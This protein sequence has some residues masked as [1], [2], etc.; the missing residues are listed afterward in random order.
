MIYRFYVLT[1]FTCL[2]YSVKAQITASTDFRARMSVMDISIPPYYQYYLDYAMTSVDR[3][4]PE[5]EYTYQF[6]L[7]H[8]NLPLEVRYNLNPGAF[9]FVE[10]RLKTL[11]NEL[12]LS[13]DKGP[14][15]LSEGKCKRS[16]CDK[17]GR[18][19]GWLESGHEFENAGIW[20]LVHDKG[21]IE[22]SAVFDLPSAD[23]EDEFNIAMGHIPY[24]FQFGLDESD[25]DQNQFAGIGISFG[26]NQKKFCYEVRG[27]LKDGPAHQA[28]LLPGD[29]LIEADGKKLNEMDMSR[30]TSTLRGAENSSLDLKVYRVEFMDDFTLTRQKIDKNAPLEILSK[31]DYNLEKIYFT[32]MMNFLLTNMAIEQY[33]NDF[34]ENKRG[35]DVFEF[36]LNM[37]DDVTG[38]YA[39]WNVVSEV[40]ITYKLHTSSNKEE[41]EN[42][43][44]SFKEY[45]TEYCKSESLFD[46]KDD[47]Y[48]GVIVQSAMPYVDDRAHLEIIGDELIFKVVKPSF[49]E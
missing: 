18:I 43:Y 33:K 45:M 35:S 26:Y 48:N 4:Q 14:T 32:R 20:V 30:V 2:S 27:V 40:C 23:Q 12:S 46:L 3:P 6:V 37:F 25:L 24:V 8:K 49:S 13:S 36:Q 42:K 28:G 9:S 5:G 17:A 47:H 19:Y 21:M 41:L 15:L 44:N 29:E 31:K 22:I 10:P 16:G 34:I 11:A 1:V 38:T 39:E 7:K